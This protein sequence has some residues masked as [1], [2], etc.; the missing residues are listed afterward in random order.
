MFKKL[1]PLGL[2]DNNSSTYLLYLR[3][4]ITTKEP[5]K[6]EKTPRQTIYSTK[7]KSKVQHIELEEK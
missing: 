7:S 3:Y 5:Y 6:E 2:K 1:N 4:K